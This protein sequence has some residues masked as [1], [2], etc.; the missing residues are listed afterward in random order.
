[1]TPRPFLCRNHNGIATRYHGLSFSLGCLIGQLPSTFQIA[2]QLDLSIP[3]DEHHPLKQAHLLFHDTG[4][5]PFGYLAVV[6][7][8]LAADEVHALLHAGNAG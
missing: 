5:A 6:R 7:V 2:G 3:L 1:M 8:K 4:Y